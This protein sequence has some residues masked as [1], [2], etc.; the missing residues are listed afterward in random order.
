MNTEIIKKVQ[1][2]YMDKKIPAIKVG[3]TV[4][5]DTVIREGNKQRIQK[6]RGLIIS[7]T[8]T[9]SHA[10]FTVRKISYGVGVEKKLPVYS[11]NV[12]AIKILKTEPVRRSKLYFMRN[13]VGKS[14]LR[15]RKGRTV[16]VPEEGQVPT[17]E[18]MDEVAS[19]ETT[20][21]VEETK[22]AE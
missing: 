3:D 7:M 18:V 6:F 22:A 16:L 1:T 4:E 21:V 17:E 11:P 10:M 19:V 14:A 15:V 20:P 2:K 13:R 12:A 8:G 9:G 5:V